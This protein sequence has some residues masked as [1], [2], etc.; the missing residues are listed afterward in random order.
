M[1]RKDQIYHFEA[2]IKYALTDP[3]DKDLGRFVSGLLEECSAAE[4]YKKKNDPLKAKLSKDDLEVIAAQS[5]G[6]TFHVMDGVIWYNENNA[7]TGGPFAYHR[8]PLCKVVSV[9][10]FN[11]LLRLGLV[12]TGEMDD[13]HGRYK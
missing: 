11:K 3:S 13:P 6:W 9:R 12:S 4:D 8:S 5:K 7:Q 2:I 1:T 10:Q